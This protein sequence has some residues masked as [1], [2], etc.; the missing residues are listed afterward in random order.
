MTQFLQ[1]VKLVFWCALILLLGAIIGCAIEFAR[2]EIQ[3][4]HSLEELQL[5]EQVSRQSIFHANA[6]IDEFGRSTKALREHADRVLIVVGATATTAEKASRA[7]EKYWENYGQQVATTIDN[8]N[9]LI[10]HT[11]ES[12]NKQLV[13]QLVATL[14]GTQDVT[15]S[16]TE[17]IA[18]LQ[19]TL[20][21]FAD[22]ASDPAIKES[23]GNIAE[24]SKLLPVLAAQTTA[25]M[26]NVNGISADAKKVADE[27]ANPVK[28]AW[29]VVKAIGAWGVKVA[30]TIW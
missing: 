27:Y 11:D 8:A 28:S 30:I 1:G 20:K 6:T 25:A 3:G 15:K 23:I 21:A 29:S 2:L 7:Q 13:P 22:M 5:T 10:A 14:Q 19:P 12:I 9:G 16:A 24:A 4:R 26:T 17:S 18:A